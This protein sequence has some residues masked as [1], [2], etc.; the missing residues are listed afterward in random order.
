MKNVFLLVVCLIFSS[1]CH[2]S[3][4]VAPNRAAA[5]SGTYTGTYQ[6]YLG[7]TTDTTYIASAYITAKDTDSISVVFAPL[8]WN[9]V[10]S[11]NNT[12]LNAY[13]SLL[14][15]GRFTIR[16]D[17]FLIKVIAGSGTAAYVFT[18]FTGLKQQ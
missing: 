3:S 9:F 12:A 4:S 16:N 6:S 1:G 15:G 10:S 8:S 13:P 7:A 18:S 2:K 11:I 14:C 5:L 17:S